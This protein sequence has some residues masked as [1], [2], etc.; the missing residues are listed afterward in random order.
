[1]LVTR[2]R[3]IYRQ[4]IIALD[5]HT[6]KVPSRKHQEQ[7]KA[8]EKGEFAPFLVRKAVTGTELKFSVYYSM[9]AAISHPHQYCII[10]YA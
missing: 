5:P 1:M 2:V 8:A 7:D 10:Y 9:F 4:D 3:Y 6:T